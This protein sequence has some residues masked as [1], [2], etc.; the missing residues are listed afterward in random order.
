MDKIDTLAKKRSNPHLHKKKH[1]GCIK[2]DCVKLNKL[3]FAKEKHTYGK[4]KANFAK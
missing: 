4:K 1:V 3:K 2:L